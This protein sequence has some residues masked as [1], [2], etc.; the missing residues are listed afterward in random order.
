[1]PL[2][3]KKVTK[4]GTINFFKDGKYLKRH[5]VPTELID[6]EPDVEVEF[7]KEQPPHLEAPDKEWDGPVSALSGE[8]ATRRRWLNQ[9]LYWL[10][11]EEYKT[12]NLGKLAEA[13]RKKA[14][15]ETVA[16]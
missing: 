3:K 11:E 12:H 8:P 4:K 7:P 2:Y 9:N 10:T 1:M 6:I 16:E 14:E 13:L 15:A 5:E